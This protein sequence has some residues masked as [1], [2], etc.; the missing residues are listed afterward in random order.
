M[1]TELFETVYNLANDTYVPINHRTMGAT[2]AKIDRQIE[3][4]RGSTA[5]EILKNVRDDAAEMVARADIPDSSKAQVITQ[6]VYDKM[7]E[8]R[9]DKFQAAILDKVINENK[10]KLFDYLIED[11]CAGDFA[12]FVPEHF[13]G[14]KQKKEQ[15][16]G[17]SS[18]C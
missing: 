5:D 8:P 11:C 12:G 14:E 13:I 17:N 1:R 2:T 16:D 4:P 15:D 6:V 9:N 7:T 10:K 18:C 3:E